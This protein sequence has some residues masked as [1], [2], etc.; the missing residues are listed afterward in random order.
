[1]ILAEKQ[2]EMRSRNSKKVKRSVYFDILEKVKAKPKTVKFANSYDA[3]IA[4]TCLRSMARRL[5]LDDLNVI[6]IKGEVIVWTGRLEELE[7]TM[8]AVQKRWPLRRPAGMLQEAR[9]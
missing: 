2:E 3:N 9:A 1:M 8:P 6:Q 5:M 7:F 4:A